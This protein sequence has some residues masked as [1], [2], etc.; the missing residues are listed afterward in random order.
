MRPLFT[1]E[2]CPNDCD[3]P[4]FVRYSLDPYNALLQ[5]SKKV[6]SQDR[7]YFIERGRGA[8][9]WFALGRNGFWSVVT[10][11]TYMEACQSDVIIQYD[12]HLLRVLKN[13]FGANTMTDVP[14][15]P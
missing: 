5:A 15:Q 2:F 7:E 13:R 12:G 8:E 1:G 9:K 10:K 14:D 11:Y 4:G 3:K 6:L